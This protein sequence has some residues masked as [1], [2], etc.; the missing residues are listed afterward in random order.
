LAQVAELYCTRT[1]PSTPSKASLCLELD[2]RYMASVLR[3]QVETETPQAA[4]SQNAGT[5]KAIWFFQGMALA[6]LMLIAVAAVGFPRHPSTEPPSALRGHDKAVAGWS[7]AM[8]GITGQKERV[9]MSPEMSFS[10]R[11]I[12][13]G[14]SAA[15]IGL[16]SAESASAKA[17]QF[18][19]QEI[20]GAGI[21]SP[22]QEGG[23]KSGPDATFGYKSTGV[24]LATG[25]EDDVT[26]E[27]AA[28]SVSE[29]ILKAQAPNIESQ[30][31]WL[32]RDNMRGQAYNAKANM[33]A[34]NKVSK[35][36][37]AAKRLYDKVWN[38]ANQFDLALTKKE[39]DLAI[40]EYSDFLAALDTWVKEV[41]G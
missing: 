21:S 18:G 19:K 38:E 35:D 14:A 7:G 37:K 26:R 32:V 34:L 20:F 31:W 24:K 13:A 30:T 25:Y 2:L 6:G 39:K 1:I 4:P 3:L 5:R 29:K 12:V 41:I 33:M 9:Q 10:R 15:A 36:P 23:P 27:K 8:L 40:K 11:S 22:Y 16:A 28:F 17:G